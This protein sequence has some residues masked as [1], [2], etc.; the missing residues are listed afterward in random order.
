MHIHGGAGAAVPAA[1]EGADP[2]GVAGVAE[3]D[4]D[5]GQR[6]GG[7]DGPAAG[8]DGAGVQLGPV[9]AGG[10]VDRPAHRAGLQHRGHQQVGAEA[11]FILGG[12][13]GGVVG[14]F[15]EQRA[16]HRVA[17]LVGGLHDLA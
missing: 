9:G 2:V 16:Q 3:E 14:E 13:G 10:Q 15:I 7:G 1:S 6:R 12:P 17:G 4:R 8:V 5:G 11:V